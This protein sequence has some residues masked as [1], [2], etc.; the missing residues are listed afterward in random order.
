MSALY[1]RYDTAA[2][3]PRIKYG[4]TRQRRAGCYLRI[5]RIGVPPV[6]GVSSESG[7]TGFWNFRDWGFRWGWPPVVGAGILGSLSEVGFRNSLWSLPAP[8][9]G[10]S[11]AL[12]HWC[13]M[14]AFWLAAMAAVVSRRCHTWSFTRPLVSRDGSSDRSFVR[15]GDADWLVAVDDRSDDDPRWAGDGFPLLRSTRFPLA[16]ERRREGRDG[17]LLLA[18]RLL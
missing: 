14:T 1:G 17:L 9:P 4:V 18:V 11:Y 10:G 13:F 5:F 2:S 3:R 12:P 15:F 16:R 6:G 7:F 8:R